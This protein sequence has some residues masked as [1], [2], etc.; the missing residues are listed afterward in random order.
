MCIYI[1]MYNYIYT[2]QQIHVRA[3][4]T[5]LHFC[6]LVGWTLEITRSHH[7]GDCKDF[8]PINALHMGDARQKSSNSKSVSNTSRNNK[9]YPLVM[10]NIAMEAMAHRNRCFT[11]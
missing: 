7:P 8:L 10:T 3:A 6:H 9:I 1:Y 5:M 2:K 4:L 11:Y